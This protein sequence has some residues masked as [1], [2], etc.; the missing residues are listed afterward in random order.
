MH[1]LMAEWQV[2]ATLNI[3]CDRDT[4][5]LRGAR[6][7]FQVTE[8][9]CKQPAWLGDGLGAGTRA[10]GPEALSKLAIA[11]SVATGKSSIQVC[12]KSGRRTAYV[13]RYSG[14]M[15]L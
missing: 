2:P 10:D 14:T 1:L 4:P 6:T 7:I 12:H 11:A 5:W 9:C 13:L 3:C 15:I 8:K